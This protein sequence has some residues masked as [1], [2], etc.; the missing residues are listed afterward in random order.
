M[1]NEEEKE[2]ERE[3]LKLLWKD[4]DDLVEKY[5]NSISPYIF[6]AA[7]TAKTTSMALDSAPTI[8]QALELIHMTMQK[9]VNIHHKH[10]EENS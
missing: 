7:I 2:R 9:A 6:V 5:K 3:H 4:F 1:N 8:L 10:L